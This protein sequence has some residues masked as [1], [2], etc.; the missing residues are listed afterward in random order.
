[1]TEQHLYEQ[2]LDAIRQ[3][4]KPGDSFTE[5]DI[6]IERSNLH[7]RQNALWVLFKK[8]FLDKPRGK[9]TRGR[10]I[11]RSRKRPERNGEERPAELVKHFARKPAPKPVVR[12]TPVQA[13]YDL[14]DFMAKAEPALK[15]AAKILEAVDNA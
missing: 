9:G 1:M 14:L 13:I 7:T 3:K 12:V 4:Y 15:R 11:L 6:G 2:M 8:G 5:A 10:Y